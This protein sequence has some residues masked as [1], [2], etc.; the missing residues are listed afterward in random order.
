MQKSIPPSHAEP[1][2]EF[3]PPLVFPDRIT[4]EG[5]KKLQTTKE[6]PVSFRLGIF[7]RGETRYSKEKERLSFVQLSC[8]TVLSYPK[9][10]WQ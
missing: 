9:F 7:Q 5:Q 10:K 3:S 6:A 1:K 4:K 2:N 8:S